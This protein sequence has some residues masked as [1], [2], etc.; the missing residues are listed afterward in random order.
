MNLNMV[1]EGK[2]RFVMNGLNKQPRER[3]G[4][5]SPNELFKG[6]RVD[7]FAA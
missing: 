2:I 7:L 3:R 6:L 4:N 1:I 5:K